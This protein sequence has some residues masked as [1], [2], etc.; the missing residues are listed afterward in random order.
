[1]EETKDRVE[2]DIILDDED[3]EVYAEDLHLAAASGNTDNT[4]PQAPDQGASARSDLADPVKSYLREMGSVFLLDR[5]TEVKLAKEIEQGKLG[6]T[7]E[8]LRSVITGDEL[9]A[10]RERLA[11]RREEEDE[12]VI[13]YDD[14]EGFVSE[15]PAELRDTLEKIDSALAIIAARR[16]GAGKDANAEKL[17]ALLLEIEK[18]TDIYERIIERLGETAEELKRLTRK[19]ASLQRAVKKGT[20]AGALKVVKGTP[21]GEGLPLV[22]AR[23][24]EL[25]KAAGL[26]SDEMSGLLRAILA[27]DAQIDHARERLI[28]A[29]LRL[30]VS[31]ARRYMNRGLQFLDLIQ[32]GNI[33]LMRAVEKF[34]YRRGYKF[35]TYATWWIRQAISRSIA[36]QGR[37]IRIPVHMIETINKLLHISHSFVQQT[38]REPTHEELAERMD[39]TVEKIRKIMKIA[40]EPV[41][42]ETPV[43]EDGD[44]MLGDFIEDTGAMVPHDEIISNDL[45]EHM[46]EVLSTLS[47][48]EEKVLRMRFGIGEAKDH[49]LEE[50]GAFF[51]VTRERIRQIESKALRKLRHPKRCKKLKAFSDK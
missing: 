10:L 8:L 33:G 49:T 36:D 13:E 23:I 28:K 51:N 34:E 17:P 3:I 50:V 37:T 1:M 18:R 30:V 4:E 6:I 24:K 29:N 43:G 19:R 40:K 45:T 14:D 42:L 48:R 2:A 27:W 44:S 12:D 5:E 9:A 16:K 7:N 35:S 26:E 38:G 41:S 39:L 32:E 22:E 31:I 47:P 15:D 11:R 25:T 20:G 21:P 46:N